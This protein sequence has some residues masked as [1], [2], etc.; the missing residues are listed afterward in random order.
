MA[1][2]L[3][4]PEA[5]FGP[6]NNCAGIGQALL[7]RGHRV[8]FVVEESFAGTLEARGFEER[9]VQLA[10]PPD[11]P[12]APGQFWKD[13]VRETS[14][15]FRRPT[16]EALAGFIKP[17]FE[18]LCDG[19]RYVDARLAD[20]LAEV[21]PDV[22]VEDNV[23]SFPAILARGR[24][25]VRIMSCNPL[26][27]PD[28]D[29]PPVFSGYP[30]DDR[31]QWGEYRIEAERVLGPLHEEF[32]HACRDRG[33]PPLPRGEFIHTS[34]YLNLS[35]YPE[36]LDY[37]RSQPLPGPWQRLPANVRESE[38]GYDV[39]ADLGDPG[40]PLVY[41]SLGSLGSADLPLMRQLVDALGQLDCRVIVSKGPLHDQLELPPGMTGAEYLPQIAVLPQVDAVITHG[42]N[43]TVTECLYFGKPMIVLP[44][45][46]DQHD[47]AQ[48][49]HETGLG[50]RLSTYEAGARELGAALDAVLKDPARAGRLWD[51]SERLSAT[52]GTERAADLLEGVA[53]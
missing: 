3:F 16:I 49:V 53:S 25:W 11:Q 38:T 7:R 43:N 32:D 5:A 21:D 2:F 27:I 1:T 52:P 47:N 42:G 14:P 44:L 10:P 23:V 22:T 46:W 50:V 33:A 13:F 40:L 19:A 34:S 36:E 37:A 6:T 29:L 41:L 35:L 30:T 45:F 24:P 48:R 9:L 26:E 28:P 18:A 12:Q 17:T 20:V 39:P 15:I 4:F 51:I 31:T 8:V